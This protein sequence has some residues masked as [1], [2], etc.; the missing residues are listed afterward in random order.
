M[1]DQ[2]SMLREKVADL[3]RQ[4]RYYDMVQPLEE[5]VSLLS[6]RCSGGGCS[7]ARETPEYAAALDQLGGLHRNLGNLDRAH[8]IYQ[9][10]VMTSATV[11]GTDDPN[12]ATTLN[13]YAGL[14]RLR[15]D[16][17]GADDAYQ[18]AEKVYN[19][20]IGP[21]HVLTISCL[22]NRGLLRQDQGRFDE[23]L[24]LHHEALRRLRSVPGNEVAEATTLNNIASVHAKMKDYAQARQYMEEASEIYERTVG[25]QS[26]LYVG[27]L[28]NLASIQALSG[29]YE[30]A[31]ERL[32]WVAQRSQEMF[33]PRSDN[34]RA[35][36]R[37]L[38][39]VYDHLGQTEKA[40]AARAQADRGLH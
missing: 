14:L 35:A 19:A 37:N 28:H 26:D 16:F 25:K 15:Q 9:Q 1:L 36:L 8:D 40:Q 24:E 10:A 7:T 32:E 18:R 33:G 17:D 31:L 20:T 23:A 6:Y 4:G 38:A 22:N 12:Y 5:L 13:N 34:T 27:Q 3:E 29:D 30:G 11:F 21:T 2:E 39:A